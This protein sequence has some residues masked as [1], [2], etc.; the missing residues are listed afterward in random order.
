MN[1]TVCDETEGA[2]EFTVGV[3]SPGSHSFLQH[4][5]VPVNGTAFT[6]TDAAGKSVPVDVVPVSDAT[7]NIRRTHGYASHELWIT[8]NTVPMDL[9]TFHVKKSDGPSILTQP[10]DDNSITN[11]DITLTFNENGVAT[12]NGKKFENQLMYFNS[13]QGY[14][15]NSGAYIFR[16]N[17][18]D[19]IPINEKPTVSI[20]KGSTVEAAEVVW[21]SWAS[22]VYRLWKGAKH[23]EVEWSVGPI[24][25]KEK[26][27]WDPKN[28]CAWGKEVISR[29]NT[30]IK[31]ETPKG[32]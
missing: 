21:G 17:K 6:V 26:C 12:F 23:V 24:P 4:V 29:Y 31:A 19:P 27:D 9:M 30:D 10:S 16:P 8:V 3:Y 5:R 22:Q 1:I 14:G 20:I 13:S 18:T 25:V 2:D 32:L 11:G 7:E 28:G 15:Q